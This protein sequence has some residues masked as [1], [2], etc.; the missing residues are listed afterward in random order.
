MKWADKKNRFVVKTVY[1]LDKIYT[2]IFSGNS[3]E[4]FNSLSH[5]SPDIPVEEHVSLDSLRDKVLL[6]LILAVLANFQRESHLLCEILLLIL[7][8]LLFL[9]AIIIILIVVFL[10]SGARHSA[11]LN[12]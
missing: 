4:E 5:L 7:I 8:F 6:V 1:I 11:D 9:S 12:L 3:F 10:L 2:L